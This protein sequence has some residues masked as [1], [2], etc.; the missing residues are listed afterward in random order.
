MNQLN[1]LLKY[2][3]V[4]GLKDVKFEMNKLCSACQAGN[5]VDNSH[6]YKSSMSTSR[7]LE[8][9]HIDLFRPTT[10][11]SIGGNIYCLVIVDNFLYILG[12]SF[13]MIISL[14]LTPSKALLRGLK[15][16]LSS[17]SRRWEMKMALNSRI[18]KLKILWWEGNQ[19]W[20]LDQ[21]YSRAKWSS[22]K[23]ESNSN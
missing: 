16:N 18:Q 3:E 20:I 7:P 12:Y 5:Q 21:V 23:E 19:A 8:L 9:L 10:Y 14:Y 2:D 11:V 17:R 1:R 4:I 13:Y 22:W 15:T 6:P